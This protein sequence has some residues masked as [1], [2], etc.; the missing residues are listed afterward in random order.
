MNILARILCLNL[1]LFLLIPSNYAIAVD[2]KNYISYHFKGISEYQEVQKNIKFNDIKGHW[3]ENAI[4]QMASLSMARGAG[5][6]Y[7]YPDRDVSYAESLAFVMRLAG[8]ER[9][10]TQLAE[11]DL[12]FVDTAGL[13]KYKPEEDWARGYRQL[14]ID[15]GIISPNDALSIN[16]NQQLLDTVNKELQKQMKEY[17]KKGLSPIQN[18]NIQNILRERL[19]RKYTW[20][21]KASREVVA[22][23]MARALEIPPIYGQEQQNIYNFKDWHNINTDSIPYMEAMLQ[24]KIITGYPDGNLYPKNPVSRA[25]ITFMM[26][27]AFEQNAYQLGYRILRGYI[28][29][30]FSMT[31]YEAN[32][33]GSAVNIEEKFYHIQNQDFSHTTLQISRSSYPGFNYNINYIYN[34]TPSN[35]EKFYIGDQ[36]K[37]IINSNNQVVYTEKIQ[38]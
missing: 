37:Y 26:N 14:A 5:H 28:Q 6:A 34:K 27:N 12:T 7:F 16:L 31:N 24:A 23:W 10:A 1:V 32:P 30:E 3:A 17:E 4:Y 20:D 11:V 35:A 19:E 29:S 8:L 2:G 9:E 13:I 25:Q 15:K 21:Q 36:I 22:V 38:Y 18:R 33:F